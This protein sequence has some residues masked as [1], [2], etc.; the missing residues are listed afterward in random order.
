MADGNDGDESGKDRATGWTTGDGRIGRRSFAKL[1]GA[2]AAGTALAAGGAS[3][4]E[5]VRGIPFAN[6]VHA[7][8][9]AGMDPTGDQPIDDA[10]SNLPPNTLVRFP[11]GEYRLDGGVRFQG[12]GATYGLQGV[13]DDVRFKPPQGVNRHLLHVF[14]DQFLFENI[15]V[16]QRAP[17]TVVGMRIMPHGGFHVRDVEWLGRG[18]NDDFDR[19]G[20]VNM[21]LA[22]VQDPDGV[23]T[24]RNVVAKKIGLFGSAYPDAGAPDRG[25]VGIFAGANHR[26]TIRIVDCDFRE[27]R[28]N[29]LYMS[30]TPGYVQVEDSYFENNNVSAIRI[31]GENSWAKNCRIVADVSELSDHDALQPRTGM[32]LRGTII[33]QKAH[34][35]KPGPTRIENCVFEWRDLGPVN[36][37]GAI[38]VGPAGRNV[39]VRDCHVDVRTDGVPA[40]LRRAPGELDLP[41]PEPLWLRMEGLTVTGDA[42]GGNAVEL[43]DASGSYLRD[44]CIHQPGSNRNGVVFENA[45]DCRVEDSTVDVTGRAVQFA[46]ASG[47]THDVSSDGGCQQ[48]PSDGDPSSDDDS[49]GTD[50]AESSGDAGSADSLPDVLTIEDVLDGRKATYE[51]EVDG[52]L[53]KS[54]AGDATVDDH[55]VVDGTTVT[56]HVYGGTD[57][58]R[59]D[60]ELVGVSVDG[61]ATVRVNGEPVDPD[62]VGADLPHVVVLEG[63]TDDPT[64]YRLAVSGDVEAGGRADPD[65]AVEGG[66]ATGL[67]EGGVDD[68]R[69]SGEV[70]RLRVDGDATVEFDRGA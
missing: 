47:D 48:A 29:A 53:A 30:R 56:G 31:S 18:H 69:F 60:G 11:D 9:D 67:L 54:D 44:C 55:D 33:E 1:A 8:D 23:G 34:Y 22:A 70:R 26:G 7:V 25:R 36:S 39:E 4:A 13:G 14:C 5:T 6:V 45:S 43:R 20:T 19:S 66:V 49:S 27:A 41:T 52:D 24:F 28:N 57:R 58:Y 61:Q 59:F 68:F 40:V 51:F 17:D 38:H 16:D 63:A 3:A 32:N 62:S 42:A 12:D 21:Y 37:Q 46:G 50:D 10:L 15:D 65:E 64:T 2:A 35:D